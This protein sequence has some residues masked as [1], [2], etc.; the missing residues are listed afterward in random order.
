MKINQFSGLLFFITLI[1][2]SFIRSADAQHVEKKGPLR[3]SEKNPAYFTDNTGKAIYLTGSHTWNNLVDMKLPGT[4]ENFD[5]E[6]YIIWMKEL[7]HNFIRLGL[8]SC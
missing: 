5:Y 3:V 2:F 1:L 4:S 7:N 6:K 8:G